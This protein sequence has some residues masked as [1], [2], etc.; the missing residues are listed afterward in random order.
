VLSK[1]GLVFKIV[2]I[3]LFIGIG[4]IS[5]THGYTRPSTFKNLLTH[6]N[7]SSETIIMGQERS[8]I[9]VFFDVIKKLPNEWEFSDRSLDFQLTNSLGLKSLFINEYQRNVFYVYV[10]FHAP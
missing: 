1:P 5:W 4:V 8:S 7:D 2:G 3:I 6:D 10:P 9:R